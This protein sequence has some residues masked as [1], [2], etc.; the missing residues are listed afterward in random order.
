[1]HSY[2]CSEVSA[3]LNS[4][5]LNPYHW[6]WWWWWWC[7]HTVINNSSFSWNLIRGHY[8]DYNKRLDGRSK[9]YNTCTTVPVRKGSGT[10]TTCGIPSRITCSKITSGTATVRTYTRKKGLNKTI[11]IIQRS[12]RSKK[13]TKQERN[14]GDEKKRKERKN[15]TKIIMHALRAPSESRGDKVDVCWYDQ[16]H[17]MSRWWANDTRPDGRQ[18][19]KKR[20]GQGHSSKKTKPKTTPE[21]LCPAGGARTTQETQGKA[22]T[23]TT[24]TKQNKLEHRVTQPTQRCR[25]RGVPSTS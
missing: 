7:F 12:K 4:A 11:H 13:G 21:F 10:I 25:V 20:R 1:M 17:D 2:F 16:S 15:E 3:P 6:W 14:R 24:K 5:P 19:K 22:E 18:G 9:Q 8:T 23:E